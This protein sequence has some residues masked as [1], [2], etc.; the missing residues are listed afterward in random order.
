M[1]FDSFM[2]WPHFTYLYI[3]YA[4]LF[5]GVYRSMTQPKQASVNH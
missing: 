2:F 5:L 4:A 3:V 1:V